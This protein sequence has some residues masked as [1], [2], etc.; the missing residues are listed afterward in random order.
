MYTIAALKYFEGTHMKHLRAGWHRTAILALLAVR[1]LWSV[2]AMKSA[3]SDAAKSKDA[4]LKGWTGTLQS[5]DVGN[6][7]SAGSAK[8]MPGGI[9]VIGGGKDIWGTADEFHFT[10]QKQ[11]GDFDVAVRVKSLTAP[12]LYARAGIMAREDLSADSR[13]VFFL[14]FPDNRPRHNN[15]SAYEFQ[16]RDT[17]GGGSKGIY[18]PAQDSGATPLFPVE[19]PN[20]WLR[21]KRT[22]NEFLAFVSSDGKNWKKY[23]SYSLDLPQ[24][25]YLGLAATS[26]TPDATI[27]A[28]FSDLITVK[29]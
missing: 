10:Y 27:D 18:P 3:A 12:Q 5:A 19:F 1:L 24:S 13:H 25:V 9:A 28:V 7:S 29:P 16:Y 21:L 17:K 2:G 20:A 15:T 11:A 6:P 23:S 22:G 4:M 8:A 14:V 26:H